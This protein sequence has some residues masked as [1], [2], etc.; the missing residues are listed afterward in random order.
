MA[1]RTGR[2]ALRAMTGA[3]GTGL[4]LLGAIALIAP[5]RLMAQVGLEAPGAL[6]LNFMRGDVAASLILVGGLALRAM[7]H[8]DGRLLDIPLVWAALVIGGR[9][10]GLVADT[11]GM[12]HA[13]ALL[14]ALVLA[15][16]MLPARLW[17][18]GTGS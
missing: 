14:P 4:V 5:A 1:V 11:G 18:R 10:L 15:G 17:M 2:L 6:G 9:L 7:R 3:A 16:L 12:A 13:G 8:G